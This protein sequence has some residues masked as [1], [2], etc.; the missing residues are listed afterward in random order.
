MCDSVSIQTQPFCVFPTSV[1][2]CTGKINKPSNSL[3]TGLAGE[4]HPV[5]DRPVVKDVLEGERMR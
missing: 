3:S 1:N 2:D 4:A 5:T